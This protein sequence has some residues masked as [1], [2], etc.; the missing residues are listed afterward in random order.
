M[1][2][3]TQQ[4]YAMQAR[5]IE[6]NKRTWRPGVFAEVHNTVLPTARF[7]RTHEAAYKAQKKELPKHKM[8]YARGGRIALQF[9]DKPGMAAG[10]ALLETAGVPTEVANEWA[11]RSITR[12]VTWG[13][14]LPE[15]LDA[16]LAGKS[17]YVWPDSLL[18]PISFSA[19]ALEAQGRDPAELDAFWRDPEAKVYQFLG[20]DNVF[21]YVLMQG[22]MWLGTQADP[23]R[24]PEAGELQ[25]TEILGC[26]HL[27]VNGEKMS[28]SRGN[29]LTAAGLLEDYDADQVRYYLALLG[30]S[31]KQSNFDLESFQARNRFLAGPMNAAF[32]RP[33][34]AAHSRFEGKVPAG[35]LD[36]KV[37]IATAR[38]VQRYT[39]AMK[40]AEYSSMLFDLENYARII[41]SQFAQYKPHDDRFDEEKRRDALYTCFMVLKTL[42]IMLYPFTPATMERLR[43]SLQLPADVFSV[44]L[45]GTPMEDGHVLGAQQVYYPGIDEALDED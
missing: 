22:A 18:A 16:D 40:R 9:N 44:D 21:F 41:N 45:L 6:G 26:F 3:K 13:V 30:L 28:K 24:M 19:A 37:V 14:S 4:I 27:L 43:E 23:H 35:K 34:S 38:M 15:D 31:R 33:I 29:F 1:Q 5:R 20:Q 25:L 36:E 42:M 2:Q 10:R 39:A 12:D 8:K 32:E 7:E 11:F 17:L